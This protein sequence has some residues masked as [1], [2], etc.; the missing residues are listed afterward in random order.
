MEDIRKS[1]KSLS[2]SERDLRNANTTET[3]EPRSDGLPF[4]E[5]SSLDREREPSS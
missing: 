2:E 3:A 4:V 1:L 5:C